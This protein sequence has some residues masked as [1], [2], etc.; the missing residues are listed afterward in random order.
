MNILKMAE[1]SSAFVP[2][3]KLHPQLWVTFPHA[4]SLSYSTIKVYLKYQALGSLFCDASL[5]DF[6]SYWFC[7]LPLY[8]LSFFFVASAWHPDQVPSTTKISTKTT[9]Q[10]AVWLSLIELLWHLKHCAKYN[11]HYPVC[12]FFHNN[13][14]SSVCMSFMRKVMFRVAKIHQTSQLV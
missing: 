1:L 6:I 4:F 8:L 7:I 12:L 14:K 9:L 11:I 13:F 3:S 10:W 2:I 5:P